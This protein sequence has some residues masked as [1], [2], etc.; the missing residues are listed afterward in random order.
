MHSDVTSAIGGV[1]YPDVMQ[2]RSSLVL[3]FDTGVTMQDFDIQNLPEGWV[4]ADSDTPTKDI[5]AQCPAVFKRL[6]D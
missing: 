2:E 1:P 3:F 4:L 5:V 6:E